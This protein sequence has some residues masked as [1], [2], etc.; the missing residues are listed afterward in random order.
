ME[1]ESKV[2]IPRLR[3]LLTFHARVHN[4]FHFDAKRFGCKK[5]LDFYSP[6]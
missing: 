3:S 2:H 1:V 5:L 4:L 6:M